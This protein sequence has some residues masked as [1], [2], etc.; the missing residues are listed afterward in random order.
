MVALP[1]GSPSAV[2]EAWLILLKEYFDQQETQNFYQDSYLAKAKFGKHS[3]VEL[4]NNAKE[5]LKKLEVQIK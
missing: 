5:S 3:A 1:Y 2:E 4:I